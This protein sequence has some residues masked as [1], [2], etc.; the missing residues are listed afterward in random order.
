[1]ALLGAADILTNDQILRADNAAAAVRLLGERPA[2]LV[3]PD[4]RRPG[5]RRRGELRSLLPRWL[6]P[7]LWLVGLTT[8]ALMFWRGR[9]LGPL[10]TEPLP[11]VVK[12]VETT[13]AVAGSTARSA[14]GRTPR[15][16]CAAPHAARPSGR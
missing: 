6:V 10:A 14:T 12:A 9:R 5:R 3:R 2:R 4:L 11:V 8:V 15:P 7:A 1:M 13:R 16:R